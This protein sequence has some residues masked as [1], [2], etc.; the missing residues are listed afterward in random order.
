[1]GLCV[2]PV[3][4]GVSFDEEDDGEVAGIRGILGSMRCINVLTLLVGL[5]KSF[6][7][8]VLSSLCS[9]EIYEVGIY[10]IATEIT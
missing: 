5:L 8:A 10:A 7:L 4:L 3:P 2:E 6:E 1:M 9:N